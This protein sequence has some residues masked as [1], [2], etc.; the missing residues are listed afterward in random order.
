MPRRTSRSDAYAIATAAALGIGGM[1]LIRSGGGT[2]WWVLLAFSCAAALMFVRPFLP[3]FTPRPETETVDV[4]PWGVR[5][6]DHDG[7]HEAVSWSDLSEVAVVTNRASHEDEDVYLILQGEGDNGVMVPHTLAVESGLFRD[8]ETRLR[9]F[10]LSAFVK[11]M[12]SN[13][14]GVFVLWRA[15][16]APAAADLARHQPRHSLR[17]AS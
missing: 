17:A 9:G 6:F 7:L 2:G 13:A 15:P 14:D 11:A 12:T 16:R 10:D 4:T 5:R 8:L 1:L 3:S